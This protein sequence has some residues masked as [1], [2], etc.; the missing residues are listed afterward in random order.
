LDFPKI[1]PR[2]FETSSNIWRESSSNVQP[3]SANRGLM[4]SATK[5]EWQCK[6]Q[7]AR[8]RVFGLHP[9]EAEPTLQLFAASVMEI[10]QA[11][12]GIFQF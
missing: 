2:L 7:R 4:K 11:I 8:K 12:E 6:S 10:A 1:V 5:L 3:V 9:C